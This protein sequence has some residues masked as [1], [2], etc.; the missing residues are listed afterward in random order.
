MTQHRVCDQCPNLRLVTVTEELDLEIEPGMLD[1]MTNRFSG[2]YMGI[3][4]IL[5]L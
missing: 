2:T 4:P 5:K 3:L 1:G